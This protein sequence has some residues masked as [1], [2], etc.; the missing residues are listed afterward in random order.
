MRWKS[1]QESKACVENYRRKFVRCWKLLEQST[2]EENC[3]LLDNIK[4]FRVLV[5]ES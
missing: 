5:G 2:Q 4:D 3:F 1:D